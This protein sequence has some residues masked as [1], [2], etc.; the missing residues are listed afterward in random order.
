MSHYHY[1]EVKYVLTKN[2]VASKTFI[3]ENHTK[4]M[5]KHG[6]LFCLCSI[7]TVVISKFNLFRLHITYFHKF[8]KSVKI[9]NNDTGVD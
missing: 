6:S 1:N 3:L 5:P 2:N 7:V 4:I 9:E 8:M